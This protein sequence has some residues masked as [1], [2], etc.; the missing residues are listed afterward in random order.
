MPPAGGF[1]F[2]AWLYLLVTHL[3]S[4]SILSTSKNGV[5][6]GRFLRHDMYVHPYNC[7]I[8][9]IHIHIPIKFPLHFEY[10]IYVKLWNSGCH[11]RKP[12]LEIH[13]KNILNQEVRI[14]LYRLNPFDP[15]TNPRLWGIRLESKY[16]SALIRTQVR[17]QAQHLGG[18]MFA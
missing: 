9:D 11:F 14:P 2:L 8:C 16:E 12:D 1:S 6:L 13:S 15:L 18:N 7:N 17:K 5:N 4:L 10:Q 3:I